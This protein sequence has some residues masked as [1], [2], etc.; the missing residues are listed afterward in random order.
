[1][2]YLLPDNRFSNAVGAR[3]LRRLRRLEERDACLERA[4]YVT[5]VFTK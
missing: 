4:Q 2:Q 3:L 1:M 5:A